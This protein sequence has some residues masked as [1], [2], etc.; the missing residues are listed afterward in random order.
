MH[1]SSHPPGSISPA[2]GGSLLLQAATS[3]STTSFFKAFTR[4]PPPGTEGEGVR[5]LTAGVRAG[6]PSWREDTEAGG[7]AQHPGGEVGS[8]EGLPRSPGLHSSFPSLPPQQLWTAPSA[9]GE[10]LT[11]SKSFMLYHLEG[12]K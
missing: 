6:L 3:N 4:L 8:L 7:L 12:T 5:A 11:S 1:L 9:E 10:A 2:K